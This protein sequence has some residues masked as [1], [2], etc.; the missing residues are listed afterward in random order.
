MCLMLANLLMLADMGEMLS[1]VGVILVVGLGLGAV[2]FVHELG[3]F[4][5]AKACGVKCEKFMIGFDIGGYKL[6]RKWGETEY[7]IGILPLGGYVKML[8]QD[9]DPAHIAD[10]MKRCEVSAASPDA[11]EVTGPNGEHYYVDRR[12][13]LA[14]SVP[15]RMAIISAGVVMN[16]IFAFIFA[17]VAYGMGVK[18]MPC[19]V[20]ETVPGSPAWRAGLETGDEIV[21]IGD[22]K[23]PT[24]TQLK[25]GVT[26]GDMDKGI[27]VVVRRA[28]DGQ[29]VELTLKP[30]Q[31]QGRGLATIGILSPW[32]LTF[33][34]GLP[35]VP[36][37]PAAEAKAVNPPADAV[38]AGF[39]GGDTV[40]RV[41]DTPVSSYREFAAALAS[42][43]SATLA[44]T[45]QRAA[46]AKD[47]K[48]ASADKQAAAEELT[49]EVPARPM[50]SLGLV[51]KMGPITAVQADSPAAEAGLTAGDVITA[52]DGQSLSEAKSAD[53]WE[54]DTLPERMRQ[55]AAA[56]ESVTLTVLRD[57][58][59][60]DIAVTPRVTSEF[61]TVVPTR[62]P[63]G[64]PALGI[65]Y[66]VDN[67]VAAVLPDS[68]AAAAGIARGDT[69]AA[70]ALIYPKS[71]DAAESPEPTE[72][73]LSADE[74]NWP[75]IFDEIQHAPNGTSV[76]LTIERG[77]EKA[78]RGNEKSTKKLTPVAMSGL[79]VTDR[80]FLFNPVER[81]R[82]A[83]SVGE[84][85]AY[86]WDETTDALGMVFRFLKKIGTQ[87]PVTALGGPITIAKAAGYSAYEGL[88]ALLI[89]L[90]MLSANLA[91]LNFL[92]IPLLDGGH[93]AFL[94]YEGVRGRPASER[95]VV[96][97]H[98]VGFV[99]IVS[100]MLFVVALDLNLIPRNL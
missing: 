16:V 100:L 22:R 29:E 54:P 45:V 68:P 36:D 27:P 84:Q 42:D 17:V 78:T 75:A 64:V 9:D 93:M 43:P 85:L 25:G 21:K 71:A 73:A 52:V 55:I 99:F 35:A 41:G 57:G 94:A 19:I 56:G 53:D 38:S 15:Q 18:Y 37:S 89:F 60:V 90:T 12:S 61:H 44:V 67:R 62:G 79:F 69:I 4:L 72:V 28:A 48:R 77:D 76:E 91:V 98:T 11:S 66:R 83:T 33:R 24:F 74:P 50:R 95:F 80:G 46:N 49:F 3:H 88:P 8:G 30:E 39:Q 32:T 81:I 7:G 26:L 20:S 1:L 34:E 96:A 70:A 31:S 63:L 51:M 23:N 92:P 65:A 6:S 5:V 87:V 10:E 2:I 40:V 86:G 82:R 58:K 14:K 97:L 59:Q 13:Y 47:A